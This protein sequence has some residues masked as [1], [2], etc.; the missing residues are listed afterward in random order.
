MAIMKFSSRNTFEDVKAEFTTNRKNS[1]S[2]RSWHR[3]ATE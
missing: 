2:A 1:K 3:S